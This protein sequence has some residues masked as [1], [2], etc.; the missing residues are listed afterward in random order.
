M[1]YQLD[2]RTPQLDPNC[3]IAPNATVIGDV[4]LHRNASIW[5]NAVARGDNDPIIIGENSNVQDGS[6]MHTDVG[7]PLTIG[8]NCTIG[9]MVMLHGCTIG[10][11]TLIGIGA[12]VLNRAVIGANCIVGA[13]SLVPEG[14]VFPD[15]SLIFGAPAKVIRA[16]EPDEIAKL[17]TSAAHYVDNWRRYASKLVPLERS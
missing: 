4:R 8:A 7:V 14:K 2:H 13:K 10:D 11:N 12:V 5:W 9:H 15:G 6:V 3:W 1:I 17:R 16:L